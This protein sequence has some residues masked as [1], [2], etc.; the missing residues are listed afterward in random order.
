MTVDPD[1]L[2]AADIDALEKALGASGGFTSKVSFVAGRVSDNAKA[3]AESISSQYGA[4]GSLLTASG[5]K[6]SVWG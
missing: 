4:N 3:G 2:K 6:Y 5:S 1:K